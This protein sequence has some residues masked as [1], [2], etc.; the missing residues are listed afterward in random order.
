MRQKLLWYA[1]AVFAVLGTILTNVRGMRFSCA[2]CWAITV[3]LIVFAV[4][5]RLAAEKRWAR[6]CE[7]A[8]LALFC[9]GFAFFLIM[10]ARV[11][12]GAR[13]DAAEHD[14]SCVIILGAGVDGTVPSLSLKTR[15]DAALDFLA[16]YPAIPVICS[17]GQGAGE[18]IT[19]AE[20]M[21][22]YLISH[23]V[24]GSRI[25]K[26]ERSTTTRENLDFSL[27]LMAQNGVDTTADFA[28]VSSDYHLA[29]AKRMAGVPW[30]YGVAA[31]M[32]RSAYYDALEVNY[33]IREAFGLAYEL[34]FGA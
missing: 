8:L 29:R 24:D 34:V 3:F 26:E 1:A 22:R 12:A 32:P 23:G 14:V 5:D 30:A 19:E 16:E 18:E 20:C 33:Y 27:A 4:L 13:T 9:L 31:R 28:V 15:L 25:W 11:I 10:E 7:R 17:G 21:A 6:R 2:L